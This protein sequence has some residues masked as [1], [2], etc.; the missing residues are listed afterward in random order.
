M[1]NIRSLPWRIFYKLRGSE[2][3]KEGCPM[4]SSTSFEKPS[5]PP[6]KQ[7]PFDANMTKRIR[8]DFGTGLVGGCWH[9]FKATRWTRG[10]G[11]M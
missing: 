1:T 8:Q 5:G 4:A 6:T 7:P 9:M 10:L 11:M 2:Q 3:R